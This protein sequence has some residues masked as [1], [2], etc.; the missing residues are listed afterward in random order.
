RGLADDGHLA[1]RLEQQPKAGAH[2]GVIVGEQHADHAALP[3]GISATIST[4]WSP[5]ATATGPPSCATRSARPRRPKWPARDQS[6][7]S[8][9]P[10]SR[11]RTA[12][13]FASAL[14]ATST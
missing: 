3:S 13:R 14:T 8:P 5:S 7:G 2:D 9:T 12:I 6:S 10:S 4:P 11:T 1:L